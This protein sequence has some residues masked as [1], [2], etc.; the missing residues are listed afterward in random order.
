MGL[1][2]E[3]AEYLQRVAQQTVLENRTLLNLE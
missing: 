2:P 1:P 3:Q